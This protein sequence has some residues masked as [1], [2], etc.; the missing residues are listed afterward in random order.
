[1]R[2]GHPRHKVGVFNFL[3]QDYFGRT[4]DDDAEFTSPH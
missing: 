1:M 4:D 2:K 3:C